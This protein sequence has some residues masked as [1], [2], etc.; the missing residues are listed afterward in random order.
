M[1]HV[2]EKHEVPVNAKIDF[3]K[4]ALAQKNLKHRSRHD[5]SSP[6]VSFLEATTSK[7]VFKIVIFFENSLLTFTVLGAIQRLI[8]PI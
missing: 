3:S 2:L 4:I 5:I 6:K 7:A 8:G 1:L